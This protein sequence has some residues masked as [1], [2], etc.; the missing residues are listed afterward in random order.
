MS[1]TSSVLE[2][3]SRAWGRRGAFVPTYFALRL[4]AV[5]LIAPGFAALVNVAVSLSDQSA[6][7]D[8]DIAFFIL[9][10]FGFLL[11]LGVLAVLLVVE[12]LGFAVMTAMLRID[13]ADRWATGWGAFR[14]VLAKS[15]TLFVFSAHLILRILLIAAPFVAVAGLIAWWGLTEFDINYY[16]TFKPPS[17]IVSALLIGLVLAVLAVVLILRL[18]SWAQALHL[19]L[20]DG[21]KPSES[22][23]ESARRMEGKRNRL[24][25]QLVF[26]LVA[27]LAMGAVLAFLAG[28]AIQMVPLGDGASLRR[29]LVLSLAVAGIWSL[30]NLVLAAIA[31]G[32]LA[33]LLDGLFEGRRLQP[34]AVSTSVGGA[35]GLAMLVIG[36][37][38]IGLW[39]SGE[40][41]ESVQAEDNVTVIAHRG[42]A[43]SRPENTM[44][45]V[46]KAIEDGTDWVEID[47]QETADGEVVVMHDSDF[48]KLSGVNL[49][50]W[51]ATMEDL[52]GID[53][54]SWFDPTY[55]DQRAPTLRD[56]LQTAKGKAKV[57]IELKYYGH[58]VDLENR[59]IAIVEELGMADQ[60]AT[61]SL[62]YP[63]VQKMQTLRP[64]WRA[65][66][67]AATAV[68]DLAGLDGDFLAVNMGMARPGLIRSV[69]A[70][71]KDFYVWTVND[72]LD[73]S[74]MISLGVDGLITDEPA[75]VREVLR[76]RAELSP[77]QRLLLLLTEALGLSIPTGEYRDQSP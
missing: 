61:M 39:S 53:I 30:L 25:L 73:M 29:A 51:D 76:I 44:A 45:S 33:I 22:F 21:V 8:Q 43:G 48:M 20:F 2:A 28:L 70:T 3:Y 13:G 77:P 71:G 58:D 46:E 59:T 11:T 12:V 65:G 24:K 27:R 52:A 19:V 66:V 63:A 9:S 7:T 60:I 56:V 69:Q 31:L 75:L 37:L 55:S 18:S 14:A 34:S 32:A 68:G 40:L 10:P 4:L 1:D 38:V 42:A 49:T 17:F 26:W 35:T 62:K 15:R 72:P 54:G 57:L 5:A 50:I 64:D 16:L 41:L 67:L 23:A 6:L 74:R 36:A 47:V